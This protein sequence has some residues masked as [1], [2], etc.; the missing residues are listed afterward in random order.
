MEVGE[1]KFAIFSIS[2][3]NSDSGKDHQWM[4]SLGESVMRA[5]FLYVLN[6]TTFRLL[7]SFSD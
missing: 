3:V 7:I 6:M 5:V 2:T 4:L 1:C